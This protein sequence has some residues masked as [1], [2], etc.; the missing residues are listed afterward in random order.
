MEKKQKWGVGL[1]VIM[2][3]VII[4]LGGC[5]SLVDMFKAPEFSSDFTGTWVR[6]DSPYNYTLTFTSN[7]L[8]ASNQDYYWRL[9]RASGDLYIV[10]ASP[11]FTYSSHSTIRLVGDTLIISEDEYRSASHYNPV[12]D[13]TGV[14]TRR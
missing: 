10:K 13:W 6:K 8:K 5:A 2:L 11:E 12:H 9:S 7:T 4:T 3:A 14:W 1:T